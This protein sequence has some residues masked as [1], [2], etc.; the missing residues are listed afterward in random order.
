MIM[1]ASH[2]GKF[3]KFNCLCNQSPHKSKQKYGYLFFNVLYAYYR[4]GVNNVPNEVVPVL[5]A[6]NPNKT[7]SST[8]QSKSE[9]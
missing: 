8:N 1:V 4:N 6:T 2:T 3:S 5:I 9:S 7:H